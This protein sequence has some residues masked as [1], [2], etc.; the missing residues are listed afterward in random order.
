[1]MLAG[2]LFEFVSH[3]VQEKVVGAQDVAVAVKLD[4]REG[5]ID[6]FVDAGGI[7]LM[8]SVLL[9]SRPAPSWGGLLRSYL[10]RGVA[11]SCTLHGCF[12]SLF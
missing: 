2:D 9:G 11:Q 4:I 12:P 10:G 8:S 7:L 5:R 6:C 3:A 1:M